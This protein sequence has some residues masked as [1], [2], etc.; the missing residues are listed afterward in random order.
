[1]RKILSVIMLSMLAIA[2]YA[3]KDVTTFLGIPV[4]GTKSAMIQKLKEKGF[5]Y[6]A[7]KGYLEGE[8]NGRDVQVTVVTNNNKVYRIMVTDAN[9]SS[10]GDIKIRF[11]TLCRQFDRNARYV[12]A[13]LSS[14]I[15]SEDEDISYKI[16]VDNKR[17]EADF[18]QKP[19]LSDEDLDKLSSAEF[20]ELLSK[21]SVWFMI[22]RNI[23]EYYIVMYYDN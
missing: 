1:M 19:Q 8:F 23:S 17:Y 21:K 12:P 18:Y 16:L 14:Q 11:N 20:Y 13:S 15:I 3:Q 6:N 9:P 4:D 2:V 10:E 22:S 7:S 5:T